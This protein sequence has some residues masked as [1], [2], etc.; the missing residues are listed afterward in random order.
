MDNTNKMKSYAL[1]EFKTR[2]VK[3]NLAWY[4]FH[5]IGVRS[6]A[7]APNQ[8]DDKF[9]V[10][11]NGSMKEFTC[12]TNPGISWLSKVLNPKGA[13]VL[14]ADRQYTNCWELGKHRGRYEA[15]VQVRPVTVH[16]DNNRDGKSDEASVLDTGLFGINI[17]RASETVISK[18]I[19]SWSAGCQVLNNPSEFSE[20]MALCKLSGQKYFTYTLLKEF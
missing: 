5:L 9:Y 3:L 7:D 2:F 6:K 4:P 13:A 20:L 16:R 8:F 15:L 12:T 19:D 14:Q 11:T 10:I 18:S 1:L 17:H